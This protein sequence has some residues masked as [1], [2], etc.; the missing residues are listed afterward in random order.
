MSTHTTPSALKHKEIEK[1]KCPKCNSNNLKLQQ[2]DNNF[3]A[4]QVALVCA[5]CGRWIKWCPRSERSSYTA[6]TTSAVDKVLE[7]EYSLRFDD[8]RKKMMAMSYYKYGA[9][10]DNYSTLKTIDAIKSLQIRLDAYSRTGNTELLCDIAN[11]AMI[12][13]MHPQHP[14][15]KYTPTDGKYEIAGFG[16]KEVEE[17]DLPWR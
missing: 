16:I 17:D 7:T 1:M 15:A 13:F 5:D 3:D 4:E 2:K 10:K 12:E 14:E 9:V 8:I 11:F 6:K